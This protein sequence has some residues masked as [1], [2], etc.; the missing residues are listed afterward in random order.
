MSD[1]GPVPSDTDVLNDEADKTAAPSVSGGED[2]ALCDGGPINWL[3]D[4]L[5]SVA[6]T[7]KVIS[8]N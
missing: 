4:Y 7:N 5:M 3:I 8:G 6:S 2:N 1:L